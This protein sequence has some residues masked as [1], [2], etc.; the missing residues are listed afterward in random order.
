MNKTRKR[1][2][3]KQKGITLIALVITIIVLLI[4]A[5]VSIATLTGQNGIL[6]QANRAKEQTD[7]AKEEEE[8]RVA[9]M[10]AKTNKGENINELVT[11]IEFNNELKNIG[12]EGVATGTTNISVSFPSGNVYTINQTTGEIL[13]PEIEE[14][15]DYKEYSIN[16]FNYWN[17]EDGEED[18]GWNNIEIVL[19]PDQIRE[20]YKNRYIEELEANLT[21]EFLITYNYTE[22]VD[23]TFDD[24]VELVYQETGVRYTN[25]KDLCVLG[26]GMPEDTYYEIIAESKQQYLNDNNIDLENLNIIIYDFDGEDIYGYVRKEINNAPEE[27]IYT[28][29][30]NEKTYKFKVIIDRY[31]IVGD[32]TNAYVYDF[33][34][35]KNLKVLSGTIT[36]NGEEQDIPKE[37]IRTESD[38][39]YIYTYKYF[40]H[41]VD[42]VPKK[43]N[44]QCENVEVEGYIGVMFVT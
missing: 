22:E 14:I 2:T 31:E 35:K 32:G 15:E 19:E 30:V 5:G 40:E 7:E 44:I 9:Y 8:V 27:Y 1:I 33:N 29:K 34:E 43:M 38:Y 4:L 16:V 37:D 3:E 28:V 39:T 17:Y 6:T 11:D 25:A 26:F 18:I 23:A 20:K 13:G 10:A 21:E 12:S 41:K 42:E 36:L 24:L